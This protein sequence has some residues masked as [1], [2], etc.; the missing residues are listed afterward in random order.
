MSANSDGDDGVI[1]IDGN[2][3]D[4]ASQKILLRLNAYSWT[5]GRKLRETAE[6][7]QNAQVFY[8][9]E[10]HLIPAGLVREEP[11]DDSGGRGYH[12]NRRRFRLT[13]SGEEWLEEHHE[14]VARP[15]SR[16][17]TQQMAYEA[18]DTAESAKA[19]VQSYRKKVHKIRD[20][21]DGVNEAVEDAAQQ[22]R[23][24]ERSAKTAKTRAHEAR[25]MSRR[26]STATTNMDERLQEVERDQERSEESFESRLDAH[27]GV[28][29]DLREE[30]AQLREE[31]NE[32]R[33]DLDAL[34]RQV[35]VYQL[36]SKF[37]EM[38]DMMDRVVIRR[39]LDYFRSKT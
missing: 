16:T 4:R 22:F 29:R 1:R 21:V 8:R 7:S 30:T 23:S 9:M 17:E 12:H 20:H 25:Q 31:N 2:R 32:L 36:R 39:V 11:R 35:I 18:L 37:Q 3:I 34:R 10:E 38:W 15:A 13:Q 24:A 26:A 19:S 28:I 27:E 33:S 14:V 6:L 5:I